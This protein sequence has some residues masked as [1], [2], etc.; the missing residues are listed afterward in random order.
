MCGFLFIKTDNKSYLNKIAN[1]FD[2]LKYRGPDY[3]FTMIPDENIFIG[4][5]VLSVVGN[6]RNKYKK[7]LK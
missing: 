7:Y 5:H 4:Q 2:N 3:S 6:L 1:K